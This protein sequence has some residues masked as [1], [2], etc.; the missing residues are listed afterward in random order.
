MVV[1]SRPYHFLNDLEQGSLIR[2][3][4]SFGHI[5]GPGKAK[6]FRAGSVK[7]KFIGWH[8]TVSD[9][10]LI[11]YEGLPMTVHVGQVWRNSEENTG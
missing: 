10:V 9:Y 8:E 6:R 3:P 11:E 5:D 7:V 4:V 1:I 2:I